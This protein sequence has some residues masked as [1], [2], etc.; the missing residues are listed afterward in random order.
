MI[1]QTRRLKRTCQEH[2]LDTESKLDLDK[3]IQAL[4]V[5]QRFIVRKVI[6]RLPSRKYFFEPFTV[7]QETGLYLRSKLDCKKLF[8]EL[9]LKIKIDFNDMVELLYSSLVITPKIAFETKA[10]ELLN[11]DHLFISDTRLDNIP[12]S[13]MIRLRQNYILNNVGSVKPN[14]YMLSA[15]FLVSKNQDIPHS[16]QTVSLSDCMIYKSK[17]KIKNGLFN[18]LFHIYHILNTYRYNS[19]FYFAY[20][21]KDLETLIKMSKLKTKY[22]NV[23]NEECVVCYEPCAI[24]TFCNHTLCLRCQT[25]LNKPEC[26]MCKNSFFQEDM[27]DDFY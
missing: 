3:K 22:F 5:I 11:R 6:P 13:V 4:E 21:S 23:E 24:K 2:K 20:H 18:L 14:G 26:P 8:E 9:D 10:A 15:A 17:R 25:Y 7:T 1:S 27:D 19:L 16:I 12:T